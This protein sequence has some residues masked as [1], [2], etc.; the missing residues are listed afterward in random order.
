MLAKSILAIHEA[1]FQQPVPSM[2][3]EMILKTNIFLRFLRKI[4]QDKCYIAPTWCVA[5]SG[6]VA[7][8]PEV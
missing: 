7:A 5:G 8:V 6:V 3:Q 1:E 2:C 4:Q